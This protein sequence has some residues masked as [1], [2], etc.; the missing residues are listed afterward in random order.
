MTVNN[1][2]FYYLVEEVKEYYKMLSFINAIS[3]LINIKKF[4]CVLTKTLLLLFFLICFCSCLKNR[5]FSK[6][7]KISDAY[8]KGEVIE[9]KIEKLNKYKITINDSI[10]GESDRIFT[11]YEIFQMETGDVN[12]DGKTDI[13]IGI[14]KPTPFDPNLKKRLFIFQIE[15]DY[16]RPLWL[17]SRLVRPLER[18]AIVKDNKGLNMIRTIEQQDK[19]KYCINEYK[20]ESFGMAFQRELA[21]SLSYSKAGLLL[22]KL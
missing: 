18:F 9:E 13:C 3:E 12:H 14:I 10:T 2:I 15:R 8:F 20:W 16:I 6:T 17:S 19:D 7:I 4:Y 21:N 5:P 22:N 11:P 1:K